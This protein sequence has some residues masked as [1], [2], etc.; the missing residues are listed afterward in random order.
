MKTGRNLLYLY[1]T[2]C[3]RASGG[4][5]RQPTRDPMNIKLVHSGL[6]VLALLF[7]GCSGP[8]PEKITETHKVNKWVYEQME[9]NYLWSAEL[10]GMDKT[11]RA[12]EP[13]EYFD[14]YLRYRT[15]QASD[16]S[17]DTYGDRFSRIEYKGDGEAETRANF[18]E[19]TEYDF[20]FMLSK[21]YRDE[22]YKHLDQLAVLYVVP[23]S[24]AEKA[25]LRRG[26]A[27][28]KANGV[29]LTS[30][31]LM[32]VLAGNSISV[33]V[34]NRET[35][36]PLQITKGTYYDNPILVD[37]IYDAPEK[38]AYLA[39]N[40]FTKGSGSGEGAYAVKLKAAFKRYRDAGVENLILDLRYNG[41]GEIENAR[42]LASLIAPRDML[43][44]EFMRTESNESMGNWDK[45]KIVKFLPNSQMD[46]SNAD[47]KD[48]YIITSEN[49]ASAS[50]LIIH[51]LR[52]F[53]NGNLRVI[54]QTTRGKNLGGITCTSSRYD[55]EISPITLR[56]YNMERESG[57]EKGLNPDTGMYMKEYGPFNGYHTLH[58]LGDYENE[59][60]LNV[61]M[62]KYFG[63]PL[64]EGS[65]WK[66]GRTR[67][68]S[69][70]KGTEALVPQ[71]GLS[72]GR[73]VVD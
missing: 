56:V 2:G 3:V 70:L 50:E 32:S 62:H 65:T 67:S 24:P 47:I 25:G 31:N 59:W 61:V 7:S 4:E 18:A 16:Y 13:A 28:K 5:R 72:A 38:T 71:R 17:K 10:P 8:K 42:L 51:T 73:I 52:P 43:G 69:D 23:G 55:W 19:K 40:H 20:G 41:G 30:S 45:Y 60:L 12:V 35:E 46:N 37:S 54:G 68:A 1:N 64:A 21:I 22:E 9:R 63:V 58:P 36:G 48:L 33:E 26:D 14:N 15:T 44:C 66:G 49:T 29:V 27:F 6:F 34:F 11:D 39:Y 53:Y 57:Y